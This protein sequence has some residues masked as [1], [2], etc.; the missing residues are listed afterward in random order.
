M[1]QERR[2]FSDGGDERLAGR[3]CIAVEFPQYTTLFFEDVFYN[4]PTWD[5]AMSLTEEP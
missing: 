1:R 4:V 2:I 5:E 3:P